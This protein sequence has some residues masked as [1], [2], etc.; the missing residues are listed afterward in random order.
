MSD[1]RDNRGVEGLSHDK[2]PL[3]GRQVGGSEHYDPSLLFPVPRRNARR[4]L[5]GRGFAAYGEDVWQCY[6]L[7]WLD[8]AGGPVVLLGYISVPAESPHIVESKSLKL[9]LNS[10]NEQVFVDEA[11]A[12]A[13][14]ADD[15][16]AVSGA[17]VSVELFAIDDP[18]FEGEHPP[19]SSLDNLS[20]APATHPEPSLLKRLAGQSACVFTHRVRSLCPVTAQPDW[21]TFVIE[22]RGACAREE[23]LMSYLLGFRRHQEFHEHCV[24]RVYCDLWEALEPDFLSVYALYTRR[25]GLAISPWRCSEPLPAPRYRL[26]RQ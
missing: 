16:S 18:T 9:Y 7:S 13:C 26:N 20:V 8:G 5:P 10:L 21:A 24:E 17:P 12:R 22:T 3:L 25:G 19:G 1:R 11:A 14:I 23:G 15:L 2:G 6:E 4:D